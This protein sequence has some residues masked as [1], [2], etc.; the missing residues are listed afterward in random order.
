M[1]KRTFTK[2]E[3]LSLRS[4]PNVTKVLDNRIFYADHFKDHFCMEYASGKGPT[5]IFREY[6]F[7]PKVLG[8]KRIERA[9]VRWRSRNVKH[10]GRSKSC[11]KKDRV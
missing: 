7:D 5:Q 11:T 1:A 3:E 2:K 6:G 4:N 9:A 10:A 8:S